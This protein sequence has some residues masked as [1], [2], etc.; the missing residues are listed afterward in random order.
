MVLFVKQW[1]L[2]DIDAIEKRMD[3][4]VNLNMMEMITSYSLI[5][6]WFGQIHFVYTIEMNGLCKPNHEIEW[7]MKMGNLPWNGFYR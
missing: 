2:I 7:L 1:K 5:N 3:D 4:M 6:E